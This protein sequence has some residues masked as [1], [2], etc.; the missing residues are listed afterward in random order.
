MM[1]QC[2]KESAEII[3]VLPGFTVWKQYVHHVELLLPGQNFQKLNHLPTFW[4]FWRM[5][6]QLKS[7]DQIT[8]TLIMHVWYLEQLSEMDHGIEYGKEQVDLLLMPII[9]STI[10][11]MMNCAKS[12]AILHQLMAVT[13]S[14]SYCG[15]YFYTCFILVLFFVSDSCQTCIIIMPFYC[16]LTH[17]QH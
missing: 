13:I 16:G 10:E 11:M 4:H 2:R 7:P 17:V 1:N 15:P 12:G 9:T 14:P 3:S 5:F 6:L 8:F